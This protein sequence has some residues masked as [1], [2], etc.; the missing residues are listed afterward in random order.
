MT[1]PI[2]PQMFTVDE[3]NK[4]TTTTKE[5][6]LFGEYVVVEEVYVCMAWWKGAGVTFENSALFKDRYI[7]YD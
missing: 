5:Q 2:W 4:T 3:N 6:Q 7:V 1:A